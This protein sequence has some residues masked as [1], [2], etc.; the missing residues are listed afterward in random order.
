METNLSL[1]PVFSKI[2]FGDKCWSYLVKNSLEQTIVVRLCPE[3]GCQLVHQR[4]KLVRLNLH[5]P[6][7]QGAQITIVFVI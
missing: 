4:K 1:F 2:Y 6:S 5:Q 3:S 7:L